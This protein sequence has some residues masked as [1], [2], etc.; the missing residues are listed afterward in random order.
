M[1]NILG[2]AAGYGHGKQLEGPIF[3]LVRKVGYGPA[4]RRDGECVDIAAGS[5]RTGEFSDRSTVVKRR[6]QFGHGRTVF[7]G[8]KNERV[9]IQHRHRPI[10]GIPNE[11]PA[12]EGS[13]AVLVVAA[14]WGRR[15]KFIDIECRL[16]GQVGDLI[17]GTQIRRP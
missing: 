6:I 13:R 4:V 16:I 10:I 9:R 12:D 7:S 5:H 15:V 17:D 8:Q 2:N 14:V 3:F 11:S 1:R